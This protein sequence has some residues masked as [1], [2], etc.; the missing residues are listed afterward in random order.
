[1]PK[2]ETLFKLFEEAY[3]SA[4]GKGYSQGL[5]VG[6]GF[7]AV[8]AEIHT[9][10]TKAAAPKTPLLYNAKDVYEYI[11]ANCPIVITEPVSPSVFA[12]LN[13][14]LRKAEKQLDTDDLEHVARWINGGGLSWMRD[15]P[16]FRQIAK[17]YLE[18]VGKARA[19]Q[20]ASSELGDKL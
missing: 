4:Q 16:T 1:M 18:L 3:T 20:A 7:C 2:K 8:Q 11:K 13:G 14:K 19:V 12:P 17:D 15:P 10:K 9:K 5:C 6:A